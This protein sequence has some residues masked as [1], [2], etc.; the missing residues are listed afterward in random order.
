MIDCVN[1]ITFDDDGD[2]FFFFCIVKGKKILLKFV[3]QKEVEKE[4]SEKKG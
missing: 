4:K 2:E 3:T 1:M